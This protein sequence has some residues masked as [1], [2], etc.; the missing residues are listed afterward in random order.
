MVSYDL[1]LPALVVSSVIAPASAGTQETITVTTTVSTLGGGFYAGRTGGVRVNIYL[2]T[3]AAV[4]SDDSILGWYYVSSLAPG[5]STTRDTV[6]TIP[7]TVNE[8]THY[9]IAHVFAY[10]DISETD[11]SN[12]VN[13]DHQITI[14]P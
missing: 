9:L 3:D 13:S 14:T 5:G 1:S 11:T 4:S 2:S 10:G 12:N 8:G 7:D 6:L